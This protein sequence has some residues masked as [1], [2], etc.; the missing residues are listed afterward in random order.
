MAVSVLSVG[1]I[2]QSGIKFFIM[3][4]PGLPIIKFIPDRESEIVN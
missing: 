1:T 3:N 4:F 2:P